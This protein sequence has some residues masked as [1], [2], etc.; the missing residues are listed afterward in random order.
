MK[1]LSKQVVSV[2]VFDDQWNE[3]DGHYNWKED[4][5]TP[6]LFETMEL[7]KEFIDEVGMRNA[8]TVLNNVDEWFSSSNDDP[9]SFYYFMADQYDSDP[10]ARMRTHAILFTQEE[11]E[12]DETF[13]ARLDADLNDSAPESRTR[14][15]DEI[16]NEDM[17]YLIKVM[18]RIAGLGI[19]MANVVQNAQEAK[20]VLD[21]NIGSGRRQKEE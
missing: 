13:Y 21:Y 20:Y 11:G 16:S 14:D 12:S 5:N 3:D 6:V 19:R 4:Q 9:W 8:T 18:P 17:L 1:T 7:A 10:E 2:E 15:P